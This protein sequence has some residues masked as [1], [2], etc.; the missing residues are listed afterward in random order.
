MASP[1][2]EFSQLPINPAGDSGRYVGSGKQV[3]IQFTLAP[4]A[5]ST[6]IF[7][8]PPLVITQR[9]DGSQCSIDGGIWVRKAVY[10]DASEQRLLVQEYSGSNDALLVYRTSDCKLLKTVDVSNRR[11]QVA[12]EKVLIGKRCTGDGIASCKST[13]QVSLATSRQALPSNDP[14]KNK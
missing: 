9:R 10:L 3:E 13:K 11:W 5:S 4:D 8:E 7:P 2:N 14:T 1:V 12:G 6:D